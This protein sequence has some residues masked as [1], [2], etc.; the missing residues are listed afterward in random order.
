M[1]LKPNKTKYC[2]ICKTYCNYLNCL[3]FTDSENL[4]KLDYTKLNNVIK[5]SGFDNIVIYSNELYYNPSLQ[6]RTSIRKIKL[7]RILS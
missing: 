7:S 1:L 2:V 4:V 6:Y 3:L 5:F